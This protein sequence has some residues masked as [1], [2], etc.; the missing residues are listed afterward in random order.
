MT[1]K[2]KNKKIEQNNTRIGATSS[3][4][5]TNLTQEKGKITPSHSKTAK[6]QKIQM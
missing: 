4:H 2:E 1:D 3:T 5:T 6:T